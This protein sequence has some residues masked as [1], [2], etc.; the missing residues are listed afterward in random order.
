MKFNKI[1]RIMPIV[2]AA[3]EYAFGNTILHIIIPNKIT[4]TFVWYNL[5]MSRTYSIFLCV[6]LLDIQRRNKLYN[7]NYLWK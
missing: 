4:Y 6:K 1:N 3:F 2:A 7:E 5:N